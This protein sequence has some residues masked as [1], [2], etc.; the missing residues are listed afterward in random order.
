[1]RSLVKLL[2]I[3]VPVLGIALGP[4]TTIHIAFTMLWSFS[5]IS[6]IEEQLQRAGLSQVT[7]VRGMPEFCT[8]SGFLDGYY[9]S[10]AVDVARIPHAFWDSSAARTH[11]HRG[12]F[13]DTQANVLESL[14]PGYLEGCPDIPGMNSAH[15]VVTFFFNPQGDLGSYDPATANGR[16]VVAYDTRA[17]RIYWIYENN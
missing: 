13:D 3:F 7:S 2:K 17:S 9:Y 14:R 11:W 6:P 12:P 5:A 4:V 16:G 15:F 8:E 10:Y 1:M